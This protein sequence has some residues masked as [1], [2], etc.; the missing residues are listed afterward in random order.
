MSPKYHKVSS[1][2]QK[3][4]GEILWKQL[5]NSEIEDSEYIK[6]RKLLALDEVR[7]VDLTGEGYNNYLTAA[8]I[9]EMITKHGISGER[10]VRVYKGQKELKLNELRKLFTTVN[11]EN[12]SFTHVRSEKY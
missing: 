4:I 3:A 10:I 9:D 6:Y 8:D 1:R 2:E 11:D 5:Y 12:I 7:L